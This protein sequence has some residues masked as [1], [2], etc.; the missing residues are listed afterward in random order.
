MDHHGPTSKEN[1]FDRDIVDRGEASEE[2]QTASELTCYSPHIILS[3][4]I[5]KSKGYGFHPGRIISRS[6]G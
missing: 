3:K 5:D 4:D 2:E 6:A 1:L